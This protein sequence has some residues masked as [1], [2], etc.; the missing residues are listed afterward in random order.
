MAEDEYGN[1]CFIA[2]YG[3]SIAKV[4]CNGAVTSLFHPSAAIINDHAY[5]FTASLFIATASS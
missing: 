1:S 2:S 5:G 3:N 4:D